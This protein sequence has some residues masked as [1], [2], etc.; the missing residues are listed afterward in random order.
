MDERNVIGGVTATALSGIFDFVEPLRWLLMLGAVLIVADLRFGLRAARVRGDKI[1]PSRAVRRTINKAVDYICWLLLA[2]SIGAT[3]GES[4]GVTI[5]P[6]LVMLVIYGV[7]INSCFANYFE[8]KG[9]LLR[10]DIFKWFARKTDII[11]IEEQ[12][13]NVEKRAPHNE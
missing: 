10:V 5:L 12:E 11:T 6:L 9:K 8:S 2:G 1:R 3:F 13:P 4:I 7:E